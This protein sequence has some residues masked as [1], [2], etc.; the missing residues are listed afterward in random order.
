MKKAKNYYDNL[1]EDIKSYL[2]D[3]NIA[4]VYID[5]T[6]EGGKEQ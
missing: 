1:E 6:I 5:K 4:K 2:E 3:L